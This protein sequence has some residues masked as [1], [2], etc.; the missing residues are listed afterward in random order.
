MAQKFKIKKGDQVIVMTG[1]DKGKKGEVIE[2]LRAESRQRAGDQYG[3]AASP[4]N[5]NGRR[6]HLFRWKRHFIF[7]MLLILILK[8]AN[9]HALA[10][11]KRWQ[12]IRIARRSG[13]ALV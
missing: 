3:Q 12:K 13:K 4:C 7:R 1:R 9:Q 11:R 2:V 5:A 10:M 8:V 6:R